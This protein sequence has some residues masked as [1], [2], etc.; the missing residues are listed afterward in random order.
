MSVHADTE[1]SDRSIKACICIGWVC[2]RQSAVKTTDELLCRIDIQLRQMDDCQ[3]SPWKQSNVGWQQGRCEAHTA[4]LAPRLSAAHY[5]SSTCR[6]PLRQT[7]TGRCSSDKLSIFT[8]ADCRTWLSLALDTEPMHR[9]R[10]FTLEF[11]G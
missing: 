11:G 2:T 9:L 7:N 5:P 10:W 6:L 4:K 1:S 3:A 8:F